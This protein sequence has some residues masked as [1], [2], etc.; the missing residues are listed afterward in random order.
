MLGF[1]QCKNHGS[2]SRPEVPFPEPCTLSVTLYCL[3]RISFSYS[4]NLLIRHSQQFGEKFE[5]K[6]QHLEQPDCVFQ[7]VSDRIEKESLDG[8]VV[9]QLERRGREVVKMDW[10]E[11]ITVPLQ[12]GKWNYSQQLCK[13]ITGC[14]HRKTVSHWGSSLVQEITACKQVP[15][16]FKWEY[17]YAHMCSISCFL[18]QV[19]WNQKN[20]S[21]LVHFM[22]CFPVLA[23]STFICFSFKDRDNKVQKLYGVTCIKQFILPHEAWL[24]SEVFKVTLWN[25]SL[26]WQNK[27]L[28]T[29]TENWGD[30]NRSP[31]WRTVCFRSP[32]QSVC[33]FRS[34]KI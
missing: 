8:P 28:C 29:L 30:S 19:S 21:G 24:F 31:P 33:F 11:H 12:T 22:P 16:T 6:W 17:I 5:I 2:L 23:T 7:D 25:L 13:W 1:L 27:Q 32:K 15:N 20:N 26:T 34:S 3:K 9:K 4:G 18:R 10:R 14:A